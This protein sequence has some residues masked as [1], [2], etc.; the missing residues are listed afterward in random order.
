MVLSFCKAMDMVARGE[1]RDAKTITLQHLVLLK[2]GSTFRAVDKAQACT[3]S[4]FGWLF[5]AR[6]TSWTPTTSESRLL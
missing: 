3:Y 4:L 1:I 2:G 6:R 5:C